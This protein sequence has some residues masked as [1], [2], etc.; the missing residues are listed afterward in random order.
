MYNKKFWQLIMKKAFR[1]AL[2]YRARETLSQ[3][4][5]GQHCNGRKKGIIPGDD[6]GCREKN[7]INRV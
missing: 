5:P 1:F 4:Y 7:I 3:A 2:N 6:R